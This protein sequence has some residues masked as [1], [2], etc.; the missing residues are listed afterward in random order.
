MVVTVCD[1]KTAEAPQS[2]AESVVW[3]CGAT[4]WPGGVQQAEATCASQS[5][6][7]FFFFFFYYCS[8]L[9]DGV[10]NEDRKF[11]GLRR[12]INGSAHQLNPF[13]RQRERERAAAAAAGLD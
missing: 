1:E 12:D 2:A 11:L 3:V 9:G 5:I 4:Q 10:E 7:G 13:R 6:W 8:F